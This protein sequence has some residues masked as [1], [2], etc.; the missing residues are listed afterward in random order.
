MVHTALKGLGCRHVG[1]GLTRMAPPGLR[2]LRTCDTPARD[3]SV[4]LSSR[5]S[6]GSSSRPPRRQREVTLRCAG[7]LPQQ[8]VLHRQFPNVA[9]GR[10]EL[11]GQRRAGLLLQTPLETGQR[12]R[13]PRLQPVEFHADFTRDRRKRLAAQQP[14]H[15]VPFP[16]SR[17]TVARVPSHQTPPPCR[18]GRR[19]PYGRPPSAP[20]L[21][22]QP[23]STQ[24]CA[25]P[26]STSDSPTLIR[27]QEN[28]GR[29]IWSNV[30]GRLWFGIPPGRQGVGVQS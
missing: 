20:T 27:V 5:R 14:Q 10:I 11:G 24:P 23:A 6:P 4:A 19:S 28:W 29:L 21:L 9:L 1:L 18:R 16:G 15:H 7:T 2:R 30:D 12:P 17:S 13:L 8:L 3:H 22:P 25:L 26:P